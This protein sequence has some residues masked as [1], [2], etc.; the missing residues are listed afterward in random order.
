MTITKFNRNYLLAVELDNGENLFIEPPFTIDFDIVRQSFSSTNDAS[1]RVY[2]LSEKNRNQIRY[3]FS[4]YAGKIRKVVLKAGYEK[5]LPVIFTGNLNQAWS[6]RE[7]TDF[8]TT[9][10]AYDGGTAFVNSFAPATSTFPAGTTY[11]NVLTT[12]L[13]NLNGVTIG[14]IGD[15][16]IKDPS[17]NYYNLTRSNSYSGNIVDIL[18][19]ITNRSFAIDNGKSFI[20]NNSEYIDDGSVKIISSDSGLLDTPLRENN[21]VTLSMIFEPQLN[22]YNLIELRS[23]TNFAVSSINNRTLFPSATANSVN[24]NGFYKVT[25]I[26]HQ[27]MISPD[28]CGEV[29]TTIQL[30]NGN[31]KL[32]RTRLYGQSR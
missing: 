27:G 28:V 29:V 17:G 21:L 7:G 18:S 30:F 11:F 1:I 25:S 6:L 13:N 4:D 20:L 23:A 26:R 8:I 15:S 2:N 10:K 31:G 32:D 22:L 19:T 12:L 24:V 14:A 5:N 16:F 9:I 3:D